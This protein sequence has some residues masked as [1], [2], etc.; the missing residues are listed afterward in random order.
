[1]GA[2]F[3]VQ[4]QERKQIIRRCFLSVECLSKNL[5]L[6]LSPDVRLYPHLSC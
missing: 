4:R 5:I 6:V 1:M 2:Y 3:M